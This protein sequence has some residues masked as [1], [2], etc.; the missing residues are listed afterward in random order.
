MLNNLQHLATSTASHAQLQ[1]QFSDLHPPLSPRSAIIESQRCLYC[2]DAP[3]VR[4]CPT[5]IDVPSFIAFIAQGNPTIAARTI[6]AENILGGSCARVCPTEILCEQ[7]CVRNHEQEAQPVQIGLL[8]RFALD[9]AQ[10]IR[11]PFQAAAATGYKVAV[12]G[13]GPAGLACAH[14]L[15]LLGNQ[16]D[17]FEASSK[18]GGLNEYGIARYK[19]ND[20]FAQKEVAFLLEIGSIQLHYDHAL[21]NNLA[22]ETL[23]QQYDGVFLGIGLSAGRQLNLDAEESPGITGACDYIRELRQSDD[24]SQLPL[25]KQCLV[26]G[27]GST[28][29]D[30]AVQIKRLGAESVIIVYRRGEAEM[31]ATSEEQ[32]LAKLHQIRFITW[33]QPLALLLNQQQQVRGMQFEKTYLIDGLIQTTGERFDLPAEAIF[34][35]IGQQLGPAV[36]QDSWTRELKPEHG[37]IYVDAQFRTSMAG[38]YAGGDCVTAGQDLTVYAVQ[39]GKLAALAIHADLQTET[40]HG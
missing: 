40:H 17:I 26:L 21:G 37:K 35:A 33:A 31:S 24:L 7:A 22:L 15:A 38:V 11:H 4:S 6:Y 10:F 13:A 20:D 12:I 1:S 19:L 34:R 23:M 9:H 16:V 36:W 29:I 3:C 30:M 14:R 8:Q 5:E 39:Q 25:P 27:G 28:A 32:Q 18:P 2:Y